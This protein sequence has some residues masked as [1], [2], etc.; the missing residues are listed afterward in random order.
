MTVGPTRGGGS[1]AGKAAIDAQVQAAR[2][3]SLYELTIPPTL[4]GWLFCIFP[5]YLLWPH[6]PHDL[7]GGW[8]ALRSLI[9]LARCADVMQFRRAAPGPQEIA[10]WRRRHLALLTLD[11]LSW[12]AMGWYFHTPAVPDLNGIILACI[13]ALGAIGLFSLGAVFRAHLLF[14]SVTFA[15]LMLYQA[16]AGT[17]AGWLSVLGL[18]LFL[19]VS[20]YESRRIEAHHNELLRLRFENAFV[21][22]QRQQALQSAELSSTSKSRF[23]AVMSHEIRTPLNGI[24]GMTQLLERSPLDAKQR[25]QVDIVRRSG[26]HLLTLVNDILDLARI[27]SGKL[28]VESGPVLV[29]EV[30]DDVCQL[31]GETARDKGLDF[32]LQMA[33]GLPSHALGDASRIKQVLHNLVGNA[34]KFTERGSV[35]VEVSTILDM[36]AGTLLR[37][38]VR[39]TGEGIAAD[40]MER[41]FAPFEQAESVASRRR[42]GT[43][44]GLTISR[45]L[46]RAMGGDLRCASTPG[47]GSVFEFTLPLL[48]C[49]PQISA[50]V[51]PPPRDTLP[52][53]QGRVLLVDDSAVNVLVAASMLERCGLRVDAAEH[54]REA[55]EKLQAGRY[56]LV[57]M[58]C[59]MPEMNGFEATLAW[60]QHEARESLARTPIVALTAS[61]VNGDRDRCLA[62]GMDDYLVKPFEMDDLLQVVQRHLR[63]HEEG[64]SRIT[65]EALAFA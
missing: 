29:R 32:D 13:V 60:R 30:V 2:V 45:E 31:L 41:V 65:A 50:Q 20:I 55:L 10:P 48:S 27:E 8:F 43:G 64:L 53:L 34:I 52:Q 47:Q 54:G 16:L 25:E 19:A 28:V 51:D 6:L 7:L 15:P 21:A 17:P 49:A 12:G 40:Q 35:C 11:G 1:E 57:L 33:S 58:D 26:R 23:V 22:E 38:A 42:D 46:A 18:G 39:D 14:A 37:F 59:Q 61:A 62:C 4:A 44:L 5:V 36:R 24:L 9:V 3:A 56:E 63:P